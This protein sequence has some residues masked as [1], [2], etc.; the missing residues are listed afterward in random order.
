MFNI[1]TLCMSFT[2]H[3][4]FHVVF[5]TASSKDLGSPT[6]KKKKKKSILS[7]LD[8]C[9]PTHTV[10]CNKDRVRGGHFGVHLQET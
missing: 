8:S 5:N 7:L 2:L 6:K 1:L 10:L 4:V 9:V 3:V